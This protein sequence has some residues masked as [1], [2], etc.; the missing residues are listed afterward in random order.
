MPLP[1]QSRSQL[2]TPQAVMV[3]D[4]LESVQVLLSLLPNAGP[5]L[6]YPTRLQPTKACVSGGGGSDGSG[7]APPYS[8]SH[9]L[10]VEGGVEHVSQQ[11]SRPSSCPKAHLLHRHWSVLFFREENLQKNP[12]PATSKRAEI[13]STVEI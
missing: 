13:L 5:L 2:L 11:D 6:S 1:P 4:P 10:S 3:S 12:V 7:G 8:C 9:I